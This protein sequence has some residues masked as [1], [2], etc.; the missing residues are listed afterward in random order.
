[1]ADED[2]RFGGPFGLADQEVGR[3]VIQFRPILGRGEVTAR[4]RH[5]L[6]DARGQLCHP[7][8]ARLAGGEEDLDR[9]GLNSGHGWSQRALVLSLCSSPDTL[10]G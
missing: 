1:M 9:L 7:N 6:H 10:D 4:D 8:A 3:D 2:D 5:R